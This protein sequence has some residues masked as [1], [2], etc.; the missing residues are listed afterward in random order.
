[1]SLNRAALNVSLI[2]VL[3]VLLCGGAG[4]WSSRQQSVALE[5]LGAAS[6]LLRNHMMGDMMHDA[7]RSDVLAALASTD[8]ATIISLADTRA[9]LAD[10]LAKLKD[11]VKVDAAYAGSDDVA[12]V[13]GKLEAPMLAYAAAAQRLV[14]AA[15]RDPGNALR[16]LPDFF[17]QFRALEDSLGAATET[18][19]KHAEEVTEAGIE[20]SRFAMILVMITLAAS[21]VGMLLAGYAVRSRLVRPLLGLVSVMRTLS[22]GDLKVV[23]PATE[24][25]DELGDLAKATVS[26]RD[27]L[28]AAEQL[29]IE[30][31]NT[32]V[33]AQQR[34]VDEI[35]AGLGQLAN[36]D[37][38]ARLD[39]FPDAYRTLQ[40]DF[41][42]ALTELRTTMA[43]IAGSTTNIHGGSSEISAA[44]DDLSRR[45]EQQAASLEETA[46]A[47]TQIT[48][49]VQSSAAGAGEA[50]KLVRST[51]A[52]ARESG[53]VVAAAV[54]AMGE[55]E[56]SSRE[57]TKIIA[58]IEKIAFQTNLL[59]LNASVEAAH[60]G[61]AGKAFAVVANEVR[62][63]A[64]RSADAAFEISKLISN[65]SKQVGNG[66]E[67]VGE[68]GKALGRIIGQVDEISA[69]VSTIAM[70]ADQQS[71]ALGQV[72]MAIT[73]MDKVT[74]QNAA[75]V[76]ESTAAARSLADEATGL[77]QLVARFS[78]GEPVTQANVVA[79]RSMPVRAARQPART[80]S[81][82]PARTARRAEN[83]AI[84]GDDDWNEF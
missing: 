32:A 30:K 9:D 55:I 38:T 36:G 51:Q 50:N 10:H 35:G 27:N 49:T 41:N 18:I 69:L 57:I 6:H 44:S 77:T 24:R 12:E 53:T 78:T 62:A 3:L 67:L 52:E 48:I 1:M 82:Q 5:R 83:V 7:V 81:R 56:N 17:G 34:V 80:A 29:A 70:A 46:A 31:A 8:P 14:D 59:A 19:E 25:K 2:M 60:A 71:T 13:T 21:V 33:A 65:S 37:L 75:M 74:Q 54:E 26:L 84:A 39:G 79:L 15:G 68:A 11:S 45:T 22:D 58:V 61:E 40:D 76:E 28:S 4:I 23:V 47:M 72:N 63:L 66:V 73:E 16:Q 64:Q 42:A 43:G 20:L